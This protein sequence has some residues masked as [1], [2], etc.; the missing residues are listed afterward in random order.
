MT[1]KVQKLAQELFEQTHEQF[2]EITYLGIQEHPEQKNRFWINVSGLLSD[3]REIQLQ[4][5]SGVLATQM[6]IDEG[7][8]F[9]LFVRP[10][11]HS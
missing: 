2:P 5:R 9:G 11:H 4:E 7:Y 3:D 8:S 1:R 6:L 10:P